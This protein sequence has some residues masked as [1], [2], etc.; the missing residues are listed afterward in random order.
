[1]N[2]KIRK[3]TGYWTKERCHDEA[4]KYNTRNEFKKNSTS[5]QRAIANN[6]LNDICSHMK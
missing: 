5:Y 4:L 1:M 2:T 6:W 3:P